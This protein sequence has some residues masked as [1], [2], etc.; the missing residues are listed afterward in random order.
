MLC[1]IIT[2]IEKTDAILE[3]N[4]AFC[5]FSI[6]TC[7]G[8]RF[9]LE[10][11]HRRDFPGKLVCELVAVAIG[12][13]HGLFD[14]IESKGCDGFL[15]RQ[16]K[17]GIHYEEACAAFLEMCA[18]EQELDELFAA[19]EKEVLAFLAA[20]QAI[21]KN[22][23]EMEFYLSLTARFLLSAVIEGDRRDTADFMQGQTSRVTRLDLSHAG[24]DVPWDRCLEH[25]NQHLSEMDCVQKINR[26]RRKISDQCLLAADRP[27]GIYRLSLPTGSGKTLTSLRYALE[28]ARR[29]KR[30]MFIVIPLLSV[31]EQNAKVIRSAVGDDR[32]VLEHHSNVIRERQ[33]EEE[34]DFNELCMEN[35]ESPIVITTLV[36]LLNTLFSG[37]T[38]CVRR[39]SALQ[40]SVLIVDEV[41]TVPR[42]MLTLFNL[43]MNFLAECLHMTVVLCSATQPA[44]EKMEHP[45][46]YAPDPELVPHES[47]QWQVF[48]RTEICDLRTPSGY[49]RTQVVRLIEDCREK[50]GSVLMICNTK[51]EAREVYLEL[52]GR[53]CTGLFH[54]STAMCMEHRLDVLRQIQESLKEEGH[55]VCVSTQLVEAG[56]DFSFGCV[57][58]ILAGLDNVVQAAGRGNRHGEKGSLCPVY[59]INWRDEKLRNLP[60][61]Q[62][63][64]RA[65]ADL[66]VRFAAYPAAYGEDLASFQSIQQ[67]YET[68]YGQMKRKA[69]DYPI[70][71]LETTIFQLLSSNSAFFKKSRGDDYVLHQAFHT[72]G[73]E[74]SVFED[75]TTD[76]IVPYRGGK[77]VIADLS[78][79][80]AKRDLAFRK[81]CI[82]KAKQYTVSLF[83][84]EIRA[85]QANGGLFGDDIFC[86]AAGFYHEKVGFTLGAKGG[87][88]LFT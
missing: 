39:M 74:F 1:S 68:L 29:G 21:A 60:D 10:R 30:R 27:D 6:R 76:V 75:L 23:E 46:H 78:S 11:W 13:H 34:L 43:A 32:L 53:D 28:V 88:G 87:E 63:G 66:L 5:M 4:F 20:S 83:D 47:I 38:S 81:A 41:Q 7:A 8:V 9:A 33:N 36:Q 61:I 24:G 67:Y 70:Q 84:Y 72:A 17:E 69:A 48:R 14:I 26:V 82:Q 2:G 52:A 79:Q 77:E 25:V 71:E 22:R 49:E 37:K 44:L 35:W 45:L 59:I 86:V 42:K 80:R 85:L 56:V 12:A 62:D 50:Y 40:D 19:A 3:S 54:L 73:K 64:Q 65:C 57:I 51:S 55:T 58:R 16:Q 31:L 15:H 18:G